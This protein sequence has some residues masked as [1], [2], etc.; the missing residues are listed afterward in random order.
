MKLSGSNN[1]L[2]SKLHKLGKEEIRKEETKKILTPLKWFAGAAF[3]IWIIYMANTG[4][5]SRSSNS[6]R[7]TIVDSE[8]ETIKTPSKYKWNSLQT[9][10]SP[11]N[12]HFGAPLYDKSYQNELTIKNGNR[13]D[14]IVCLT[15]YN[16][17]NRTIRNEYV[18][19]GESFK[20]TSIPNGTYFTKTFYGRYW[21]PETLLFDT[22]TSFTVSDNYDD[23]IRMNQTSDTY[24]VFTITLYQVANGNM[25]SKGITET[26]FF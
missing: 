25:E 12:N 17:P 4:D 15:E 13:T 18:R 21:N 16:Y 2:I 23:L 24:S 8:P 10:D 1:E 3:V 22:L 5:S 9:G 14:A 26:D 7:R 11:Y 6:N 19:A 20:M